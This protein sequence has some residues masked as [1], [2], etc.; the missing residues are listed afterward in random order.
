[1]YFPSSGDTTKGEVVRY[2]TRQAELCSKE[3]TSDEPGN[4]TGDPD[5]ALLWKLLVLLC[6]QNG[7]GVINYAQYTEIY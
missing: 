3:G 1:M 2:A 7:V 5:E 6:Q 4:S